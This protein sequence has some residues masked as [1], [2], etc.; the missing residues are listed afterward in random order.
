MKNK[1]RISEPEHDYLL[2]LLHYIEKNL[3]QDQY[4]TMVYQFEIEEFGKPITVDK[5]G[6]LLA[7]EE[8][9]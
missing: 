6:R 9:E 8:E 2:M 3:G 7:N 4:R 5:N 1:K